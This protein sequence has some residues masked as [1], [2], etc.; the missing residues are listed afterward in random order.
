MAVEV[1][2]SL[3]DVVWDY[4]V[5]QGTREDE[6]IESLEIPLLH[7]SLGEHLEQLAKEVVDGTYSDA[8]FSGDPQGGL[9][10]TLPLLEFL[11]AGV[12]VLA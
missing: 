5:L 4:L 10:H 9:R 8:E 11:D 6:R 7:S 1:D 2:Q 12:N 3:E